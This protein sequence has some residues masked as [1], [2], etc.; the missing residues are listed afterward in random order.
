[1]VKKYA[2]R[3]RKATLAIKRLN[4]AT[5]AECETSPPKM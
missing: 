3:R 5:K 4:R 2:G 1:M